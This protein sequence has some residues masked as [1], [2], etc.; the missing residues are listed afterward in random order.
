MKIHYVLT[1]FS[2]AMIGTAATVH[3]KIIPIEEARKLV[4]SDTRILASR[5][6]HERLAKSQF[7]GAGGELTRFAQLSPGTNAIHLHYRGPMIPD[8][9]T[10]P[11]GGM[12]TC[13]L[14]E[15]EE[16]LTPE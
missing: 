7:P 16:Y 11:I 5:T 9:G 13:Y 6:T 1:A 10:L 3:I 2:P 8:D 12:V 14:M 4:D 15:A